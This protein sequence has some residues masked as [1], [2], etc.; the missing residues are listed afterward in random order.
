MLHTFVHGIP[1]LG[2]KEFD[3]LRMDDIDVK[4]LDVHY[5][6]NNLVVRGFNNTIIDDLR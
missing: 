1:E 4:A 2:I 6:M 3:S 5:A